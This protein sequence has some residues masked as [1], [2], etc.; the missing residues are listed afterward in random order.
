MPI[1]DLA[2]ANLS[3]TQRF[4]QNLVASGW[5]VDQLPVNDRLPRNRARLHLRAPHQ[6]KRLRVSIFKIGKSGRSRPDE[7]RIEITTTYLKGLARLQ[8]YADVVLGY[9]PEQD[10]YVGLDPRRLEFGGPTSNASTFVDRSSVSTAP[11]DR[12]NV[13]AYPAP[14]LGGTEFQAYFRP[15]RL[16]EY[17][18]NHEVI[19]A[20]FYLGHGLF[21]GAITL[22]PLPD[23]LRCASPSP[24]VDVIEA[25]SS[26]SAPSTYKP[27]QSAIQAYEKN[28]VRKLRKAGL[29]PEQFQ[30]IKRICDENGLLGE[31]Y[32]LDV[33]RTRLRRA[34]R[35]DLADTVEWTSQVS[36]NTGYDIHSF[37]TDGSDRLIEVKST[38]GTGRTFDISSNEWET[39]ATHGSRY[40][41]YRV[42]SVRSSRPNHE[43]IENPCE[44]EK[45]G[46]L[47]KTP[48]GFRV[49]MSP[50]AK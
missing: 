42:F 5:T 15:V 30:A 29:S 35:D 11:D 43:V 10:V 16:A 8:E 3:H 24:E 48:S 26:P 37:E 21:S 36:V 4:L 28:D 40:F 50:K 22:G 34:G 38:S 44:L 23:S 33:E 13:R 25:S 1:V 7:R 45:Q 12:I 14:I 18:F 19:H 46:K 47:S 17:L 9:E 20:N 2:R 32:V 39:A 41:I 31:Q 6:L 49:K 27:P